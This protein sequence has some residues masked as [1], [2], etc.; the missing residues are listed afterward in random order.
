[1]VDLQSLIDFHSLTTASSTLDVGSPE[2]TP[3]LTPEPTPTLTFISQKGTLILTNIMSENREPKF[4]TAQ[5]AST[6]REGGGTDVKYNLRIREATYLGKSN[7]KTVNQV[8][9]DI[10]IGELYDTT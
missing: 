3:E 5:T 10:K 1:M 2:P 7:V 9:E 8:A 6:P 4:L